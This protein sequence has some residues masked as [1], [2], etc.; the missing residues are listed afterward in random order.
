MQNK[1][2][3]SLLIAATV[4]LLIWYPIYL[5]SQNFNIQQLSNLRES[6]V[7]YRYR[8][9]LVIIVNLLIYIWEILQFKKSRILKLFFLRRKPIIT[10]LMFIYPL[11]PDF[12]HR[13]GQIHESNVTDFYAI[14]MPIFIM[15]IITSLLDTWDPVFLNEMKDSLSIKLDTNRK[16]NS[17]VQK[18]S[19]FT[20]ISAYAF[21]FM[22]LAWW[23][24][25]TRKVNSGYENT[26]LSF[27]LMIFCFS[28]GIAILL[29]TALNN[30]PDI[31]EFTESNSKNT[32][33][34]KNNIKNDSSK[35]IKVNFK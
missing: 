23:I 13:F 5:V 10:L 25:L 2:N 9:F 3:S 28:F 34:I 11:L 32:H 20:I 19:K 12:R 8:I 26:F 4:I 16:I 30:K 15:F 27:P 6:I 22:L 33:K 14:Y 7:E 31:K 29:H 18:A 24:S 1:T 35:N 17:L 21:L